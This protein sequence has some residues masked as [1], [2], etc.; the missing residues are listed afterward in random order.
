[1]WNL[2]INRSIDVKVTDSQKSE[3]IEE[4]KTFGWRV[5]ALFADKEEVKEAPK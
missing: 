4:E 3:A 1:M 5:K 2:V